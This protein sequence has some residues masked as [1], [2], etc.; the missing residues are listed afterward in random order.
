MTH[1]RHLRDERLACQC[2]PPCLQGGCHSSCRTLPTCTPEPSAFRSMQAF[3]T[4][5]LCPL[6][7]QACS[8]SQCAMA[9]AGGGSAA[10][11]T[12]LMRHA[13][14]LSAA[15]QCSAHQ[16]PVLICASEAQMLGAV[17]VPPLATSSRSTGPSLSL[18]YHDRLH[19]RPQTSPLPYLERPDVS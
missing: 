5:P 10:N 12:L 3:H 1:F 19:R 6:L 15:V 9:M 17:D 4:G 2:Q 13:S 11:V 14:R 16:R 7:P 8:A 18:L